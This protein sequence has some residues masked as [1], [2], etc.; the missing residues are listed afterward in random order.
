[1][2]AYAAGI[3][4]SN[5]L[6]GGKVSVPAAAAARL[7]ASPGG[8]LAWALTALGE[9]LQRGG[10]GQAPSTSAAR[11]GG[12][13]PSGE[14]G[15]GPT[16][17]TSG[18][19]SGSRK[20]S[21]SFAAPGGNPPRPKRRFGSPSR[22]PMPM[23]DDGTRIDPTRSEVE[24]YLASCMDDPDALGRRS[25]SDYEEMDELGQPRS[26][27]FKGF[28]PETE[29]FKVRRTLGNG[30]CLPLALNCAVFGLCPSGDDPNALKAATALRRV[31]VDWVARR[32]SDPEFASRMMSEWGGTVSV[33]PR[34]DEEDDR[35]FAERVRE[36]T[37]LACAPLIQHIV[38]LAISREEHM[39]HECIEAASSL[40]GI[41]IDLWYQRFDKD[42]PFWGDP[43]ERDVHY[44]SY[45]RYGASYQEGE[46]E[47]EGAGQAV[48]ILHRGGHFSFVVENRASKE[49]RFLPPALL[50]MYRG[51]DSP[52]PT[53]ALEA[54]R[55]AWFP[56]LA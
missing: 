27:V 49:T 35:S 22:P 23:L 11:A 38:R 41:P 29:Y 3:L 34:G 4:W 40:L 48:K 18:A 12:A 55:N 7:P 39:G 5:V 53:E 36:A 13:A 19:G 47:G 25:G 31:L 15:H 26:Q 32:M 21:R 46:G 20:R 45:Q 10:Q 9:W 2:N 51:G 14:A 8:R 24:D 42:V 37:V 1:M 56:Q 52:I 50:Q 28:S 30:D 43:D 54:A 16:A 17:S 44:Q 6:T 33:P